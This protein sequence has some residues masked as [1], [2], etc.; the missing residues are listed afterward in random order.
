MAVELNYCNQNYSHI[1]KQQIKKL[2]K[3]GRLKALSNAARAWN[4]LIGR[5]G[6]H[7]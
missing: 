4:D 3:L 7:D 6:C 1:R 5:N 2:F